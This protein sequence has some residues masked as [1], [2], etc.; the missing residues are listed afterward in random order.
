MTAL[1]FPELCTNEVMQ[2]VA[3][4]TCWND[5]FEI[6]VDLVTGILFLPIEE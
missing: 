1:P 3:I 2:H 5:V 6:R 4:V